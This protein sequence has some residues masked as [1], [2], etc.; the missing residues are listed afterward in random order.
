MHATLA[1]FRNDGTQL[2]EQR[3]GLHERIIPS[4]K[5]QGGFVSGAWT[6]DAPNQRSVVFIRWQTEEAAKKFIG[7]VKSNAAMQAAVG[8]QFESI[9]VVEVQGEA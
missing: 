4:V 2:E 8:L 3:R 7:F 9:D 6:Y 1:V 5:D